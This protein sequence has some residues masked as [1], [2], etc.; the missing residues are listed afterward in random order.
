MCIKYLYF[1]SDF[2]GHNFKI[3]DV[4]TWKIRQSWINIL[5]DISRN[6]GSHKMEFGEL[7]EYNDRIIFLQK[8]YRKWS[9]EISSRHTSFTI[10]G[11]SF[12]KKNVFM[13]YSI[14]WPNSIV[15]CLYF[16]RYL[17]ICVLLIVCFTGCDINFKSI[18]TWPKSQDK[19]LNIL[20]VK[21]VFKV[22]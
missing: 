6:K 1:C 15:Y 19:N 2:F 11:A 17:A 20:K 14:N 5:A 3:Y 7:I 18:F 12:F 22:K 10:F 16:L 9:R 13:L 4:T 21:R 8:L